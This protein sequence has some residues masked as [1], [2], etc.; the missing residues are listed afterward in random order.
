MIKSISDV[1]IIESLQFEDEKDGDHEGE[2]LSKV[3]KLNRKQP[4]Y[5]YIRTEKE[6][7]DILDIFEDSR[8]RY[9]HLSCHGTK[10]SLETTLDSISFPRLGKILAPCLDNRRLFVSACEMVNNKLAAAIFFPGSKCHSVIGP[11]TRVSLSD[12]A[13]F[14]A[15]FYHLMFTQDIES[16][17][18][19]EIQENIRNL[20]KMFKIPVNYFSRSSLTKQ[21]YTY[22]KVKT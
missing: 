11:Y 1:F 13:I 20:T 3:L 2:L 6:L 16:M 19:K 17:R 15:A 8:Y 10:N 18:M 4:E 14:W 22:R 9:L 12:S 5:Y 21:G 7:E